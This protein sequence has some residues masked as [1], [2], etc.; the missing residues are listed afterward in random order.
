MHEMSRRDERAVQA[1]G[2]ASG[3]RQVCVDQRETVAK[4]LTEN[5]V[6]LFAFH[7]FC[8]DRIMFLVLSTPHRIGSLLRHFLWN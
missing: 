2:I 1:E 7:F 4:V 6:N 5:E 8:E 3:G